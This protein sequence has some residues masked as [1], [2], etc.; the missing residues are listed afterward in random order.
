MDA[1]ACCGVGE[2]PK[3]ICFGW[4]AEIF[5]ATCRINGVELILVAV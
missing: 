3:D 1:R 5:F 2:P 4:T